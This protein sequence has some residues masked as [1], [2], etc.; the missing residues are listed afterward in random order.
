MPRF[1]P[2]VLPLV[3]FFVVLVLPGCSSTESNPRSFKALKFDPSDYSH[4]AFYPNMSSM[5]EK[6]S[7]CLWIRKLFT[8]GYPCPFAYGNYEIF[9][10]DNGH[11]NR[12]FY[13]RYLDRALASKFTV[14]LGTWYSYCST[15][16]LNSRTY[17][18]YLNGILV[19]SQ[20]TAS[21]RRLQT[22]HTM[23]LGAYRTSG[24]HS[25]QGEMFNMN[26]F[27]KELTAT[28]VA[29]LSSIGL[30]TGIP[31]RLEYYR[32]IK[33]EEI[34]KL[35]RSGT[36]QDFID[37]R[38][39]AT[40]ELQK[41]QGKLN[42]A[43]TERSSLEVSLNKTQSELIMVQGL[44]NTSEEELDGVKRQLT[45]SEEQLTETRLELEETKLDLKNV[46]ESGCALVKGNL[47]KW[48]IFYS[49][50]F[51]NKTFTRQLYQK[52]K[53]TWDSISIVV[54]FTPSILFHMLEL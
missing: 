11:F 26:F 53:T 7:V 36:I 18:I 39:A 31:E 20:T 35:R 8:S 43:V 19:G 12:L 6:F 9:V 50:P 32:A 4:I 17:R 30:C 29:S 3:L 14:P 38:C 5:T 46:S 25:F 27:S 41:T 24:G 54:R 48:D 37:P 28:E 52:L 34:L 42:V 16:S 40:D 22:G 15:W 45:T 33:W 2:V 1:I 51:Y 44:F 21:N 49:R 13:S 23:V 47:T 10:T